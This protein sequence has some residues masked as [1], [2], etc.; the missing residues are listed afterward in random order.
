[1][2][3]PPHP[4]T[5]SFKRKAEVTP[6]ELKGQWIGAFTQRELAAVPCQ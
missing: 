2:R 5:S 1:M 6:L 4:P 3:T